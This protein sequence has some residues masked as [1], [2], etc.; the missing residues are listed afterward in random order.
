MSRALTD[1]EALTAGPAV[2]RLTDRYLVATDPGDDVNR[3]VAMLW[4]RDEDRFFMV[5][6]WVDVG[7]AVAVAEAET[8]VA[9]LESAPVPHD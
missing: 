1:A 9:A 4:R 6:E 7:P 3:A 8:L 2:T 5:R